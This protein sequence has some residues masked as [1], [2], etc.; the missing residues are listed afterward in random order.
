MVVG[1]VLL[2]GRA[3]RAPLSARVAACV[4]VLA[5]RVHR[6]ACRCCSATPLL[7]HDAYSYA[8]Q[9]E[10]ASRGI[11]P[12]ANGPEVLRYGW[13]LRQADH[14]AWHAPAPYG[15]VV[16][17]AREGGGR[18]DQP[19][20]SASVWACGVVGAGG[21]VHGGGRHRRP[22]RRV[23][24]SSRSALALAS[25][26]STRSCCCTCSGAATTTRSML[27][28]LA[29][30]LAAFLRKHKLLG[31]RARRR[32]PRASSSRPRPPSCSWPGTGDDDPTVLLGRRIRDSALVLPG[33]R[34]R[35]RH[36]VR[37]PS[38]SGPAGSRR[39]RAP[40]SR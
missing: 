25:A 20:G 7:S 36:A 13:F 9:G 35:H 6:G 16:H 10:M 4:A 21:I 8:A 26:S 34:R 14:L 17:R 23:A 11:D 33:R 38:A 27:G 30:G 37:R 1:W 15:P 24:T 18:G 32:W 40:A 2:I 29:L 31:S 28:F 5:R 39:S 12:S 3:D 19:R 22:H